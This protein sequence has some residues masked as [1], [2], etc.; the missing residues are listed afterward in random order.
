MTASILWVLS[1]LPAIIIGTLLIV[2]AVGWW[3]HHN[4]PDRAS[5]RRFEQAK[6]ATNGGSVGGRV[7]E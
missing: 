1:S 7:W 2:A 3:E 4:D 5:M 6:K